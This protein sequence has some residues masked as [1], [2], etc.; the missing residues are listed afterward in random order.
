MRFRV[1]LAVGVLLVGVCMG[2]ERVRFRPVPKDD[3]GMKTGPEV[4]ARIPAFSAPDQDGKQQDFE[5]LK[6][7]NGLLLLFVR[8][9]DW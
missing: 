3:T 1:A 2:Q 6:A 7:S 4:G 5:S 9:A 8:S